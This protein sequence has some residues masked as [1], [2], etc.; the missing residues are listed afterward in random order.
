[1]LTFVAGVLAVAPKPESS[2]NPS[3]V[4]SAASAHLVQHATELQTH[5]DLETMCSELQ[6]NVE[7]MFASFTDAQCQDVGATL[8]TTVRSNLSP[9]TLPPGCVV[10]FSGFDTIT[11]C[12]H[13][14]RA[15]NV[16]C[17]SI[18]A[19]N[20]TFPSPPPAPEAASPPVSSSAP[21][22]FAAE[23]SMAC[24][25]LSTSKAPAAFAACFGGDTSNAAEL[26][27]MTALRAG[28]LVLTGPNALER[29]VVNQHA[30]DTRSVSLVKI[31]T[32]DGAI[33]TMTPDH[34]VAIDGVF[35][36]ASFAAVGSSLS[37]GVITKVSSSSGRII[38]PITAS[39]QILA[40]DADGSRAPI[41]AATWPAS[42]AQS[43]LAAPTSP[44]L[45]TRLLA[46]AA[47]DA[48]QQF[49]TAAE[50]AF[51][52]AAAP[53]LHAA[54]A[55]MPTMAQALGFVAADALLGL[56]F[57]VSQLAAVSIPLTVAG[58]ASLAMSHNQVSRRRLGE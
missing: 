12:S 57:A 20:P 1:M 25:A 36:A 26:V 27:R 8:S 29:V 9:D 17:A 46:R 39:G 45:A 5:S 55:A 32:A 10:D 15:F 24:R 3:Q 2:L 35:V 50:H 21:A 38:N 19:C 18:T 43:F 11:L 34:A 28:D 51:L 22:C 40:A 23:S 33:L 4:A 56:G 48:F 31:E 53:A 37:T 58:V 41:L 16:S 30:T 44:L 47:P 42:V 6:A 49:Y 52:D 13:I 54:A 14:T 7:G